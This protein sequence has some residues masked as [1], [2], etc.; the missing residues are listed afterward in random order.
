MIIMGIDSSTTS[1]GWA[2]IDTR[3]E[4]NLRVVDFGV[5]K[6]GKKLETIDRI[7]YISNKLKE[8]IRQFRPEF[9]VL[10]EMNVMRNAKAVRALSGLITEIEVLL[11]NKQ[12]L[13]IKMTSTEWRKKVGIK[14][15]TRE[16]LKHSSVSY[17]KEKY[18]EEVNDDEG[19]A[20]CIAEAGSMLEVIGG[21]E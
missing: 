12:M 11:R 17:V 21:K 6:P 8:I 14:G 20:I 18:S 10:E 2:V 15:K 1:T 7:I 4:G 3:H 9:I 16:E 13:Y 5:V 19:D